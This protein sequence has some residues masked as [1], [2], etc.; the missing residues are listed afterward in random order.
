MTIHFLGTSGSWPTADRNVSATAIKRGGEVLL[1]DC[2][3]GTQRQFQRSELSHMAVTKIFLTHFHG[4][5]CYGLPGYLKTMQLNERTV[6]LDIFGPPGIERLIQDFQRIAPTRPEFPIRVHPMEPGKTIRF[7]EGYSVTAARADHSVIN[8]AYAIE[9]EPR[10]GRFDKPK[11]LALGV[12]EGR[13]F[14]KLQSGHSVQLEDGRTI[15]PEDVLGP[16]R[17]GRKVVISGD[18]RPSDAIARLAEGADILIHEATYLD[19]HQEQAEEN[20]HST[21]R[22]AGEV[23]KKA[24]VR[25]LWL[26]HFSPRYTTADGHLREAWEVFRETHVARDFSTVDVALPDNGD[27]E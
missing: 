6:P 3:E 5:H 21:A 26:H 8:F 10:P 2:G 11:A 20:Q 17:R 24:G 12:P 22:E 23:A 19:E 15:H 18:T 25:A 27:D 16:D 4:D 9:E 13:M 1:F 7:S 14:G